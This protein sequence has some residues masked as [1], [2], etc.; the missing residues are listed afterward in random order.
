MATCIRS[1]TYPL[2]FLSIVPFVIVLIKNNI[3]KNKIIIACITFLFFAL[4]PLSPRI[5]N[6]IINHSTY[7]LTSQSGTHLAYWVAPMI[8]SETKS[9]NRN[10][11][12]KSI[13]EA[14]KKTKIEVKKIAKSII[15]VRFRRLG[16][17]KTLFFL[18]K[19][20]DFQDS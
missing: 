8:I 7:A 9:I 19:S 5:Y 15:F 12:I 3:F 17:P 16:P 11:A 13:H 1:L 18:R 6:N 14:T 20:N 10:D 2:V 4:L